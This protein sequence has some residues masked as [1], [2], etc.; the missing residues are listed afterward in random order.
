MKMIV[1]WKQYIVISYFSRLFWEIEAVII[2]DMESVYTQWN[3]VSE[4]GY[5][6][7]YCWFNLFVLRLSLKT[8][9]H[10]C[11]QLTEHQMLP[12]IYPLCINKL[13]N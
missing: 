9:Y 4:I 8:S 3:I 10:I 12:C 7:E 11:I 6:E 1:V 2:Y 13:K 5:L